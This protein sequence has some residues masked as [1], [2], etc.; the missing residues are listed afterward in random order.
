VA[1]PFSSF[2]WCLKLPGLFPSSSFPFPFLSHPRKGALA[3]PSFRH[4]TTPPSPSMLCVGPP[5]EHDALLCRLLCSF[6]LSRPSLLPRCLHLCRGGKRER[7]RKRRDEMRLSLNGQSIVK[8][9]SFTGGHAVFSI[10]A[11]PELA[12]MFHSWHA[13]IRPP[14][15]VVKTYSNLHH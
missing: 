13:C 6:S 1:N 11:C 9:A 5:L 12:G 8:L 3:M 15:P 7:E 4:T 10:Q 2:H 14:I